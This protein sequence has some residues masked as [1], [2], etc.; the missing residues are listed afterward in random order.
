MC[1]LPTLDMNGN[2]LTRTFHYPPF[3]DKINISML[4][5][6]F[7][8]IF[9]RCQSLVLAVPVWFALASAH[10]SQLI[11]HAALG[12]HIV[13]MEGND[14]LSTGAYKMLVWSRV[15]VG[16]TWNAY[17]WNSHHGSKTRPGLGIPD[18][19]RRILPIRPTT[20]HN[21]NKSCVFGMRTT[22]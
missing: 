12:H 20:S 16:L 3:R 19:T 17:I 5:V 22:T 4:A 6:S 11:N 2:H 18:F 15:G 21:P 8:V 13:C 1:L 7:S 14:V 10:S 9:W